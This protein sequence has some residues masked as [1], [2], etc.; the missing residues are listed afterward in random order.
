M[1]RSYR[2]LPGPGLAL[3]ALWIASCGS[4]APTGPTSALGSAGQDDA[5]EDARADAVVAA[6]GR[7]IARHVLY[8]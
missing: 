5:V 1:L 7:G 8:G 2:W 6:A 4:P 3:A